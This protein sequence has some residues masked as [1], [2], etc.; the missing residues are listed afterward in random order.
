VAPISEFEHLI[1]RFFNPIN[2]KHLYKNNTTLN[3]FTPFYYENIKI[4]S[5]KN[6]TTNLLLKMPNVKNV[7]NVKIMI[8]CCQL[9]AP[10]VLHKGIKNK[11]TLLK[12]KINRD[13][14]PKCNYVRQ[15]C[16]FCVFI[17]LFYN[18]NLTF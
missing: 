14:N 2:V 4:Q 10:C 11:P 7:K 8:Q 13:V 1:Y 18:I 12:K 9:R 16:F 6:S 17:N 5:T 15:S 3:F